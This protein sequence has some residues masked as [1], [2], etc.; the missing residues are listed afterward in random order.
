MNC[1]LKIFQ[2][3]PILLLG[4]LPLELNAAP[5]VAISI[6]PIHSLASMVLEGIGE[7]DLI[8]SGS[9]SP[10]TFS[11]TPSSARKVLDA[12]LVV[13]VSDSY[14]TGLGKILENIKSENRLMLI[15]MRDQLAILPLRQGGRWEGHDHF[16]SGDSS[17]ATDGSS[18]ESPSYNSNHKPDDHA[19]SSDDRFLDPHL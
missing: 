1:Y 3:L 6:A 10:H 15:E 17:H 19:E 16:E 13:Y 14:E 7:A 18:D 9:Q 12:D 4:I 8:L 5:R 11:L 2:K